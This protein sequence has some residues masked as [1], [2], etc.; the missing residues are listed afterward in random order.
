MSCRHT[1]SLLGGAP[2][3]STHHEVR[4]SGSRR[5]AHA[6]ADLHGQAASR[7]SSIS[8]GQLC[9]L[10]QHV[11]PHSNELLVGAHVVHDLYGGGS[12][13]AGREG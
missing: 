5:G 2:Q 8:P 7:R 12:I 6:T 10:D 1:C 11:G 9:V 13:G 4:G 3:A